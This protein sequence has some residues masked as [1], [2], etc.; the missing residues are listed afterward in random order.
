MAM[1]STLNFGLPR[2]SERRNEQRM[3]ETDYKCARR[4]SSEVY[5]HLMRA[6][7]FPCV[8]TELNNYEQNGCGLGAVGDTGA[9][10][11]SEKH[12]KEEEKKER[13][14]SLKVDW[15]KLS[16]IEDGHL[17]ALRYMYFSC[18]GKRITLTR[19]HMMRNSYRIG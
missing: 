16:A 5:Q 9:E 12:R 18:L 15:L 4:S 13:F 17:S 6:F 7:L 11:S 3:T 14:S 19:S 1:R 10:W 2:V 8:P